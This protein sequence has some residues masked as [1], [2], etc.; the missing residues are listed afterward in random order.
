MAEAIVFAVYMPPQLP[1]PGIDV[2]SISSSSLSSILPAARAPT[3]SNTEMMSRRFLPGLMV[4]PYT[5]MAGR[6]RRASAIMQPG[7]FLSQPP[8]AITPS[9]PCAPETVSMESAMTSRDTSE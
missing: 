6:S 2:R 7:M 1:G 8:I 5:K 3:A 9:N 4:P